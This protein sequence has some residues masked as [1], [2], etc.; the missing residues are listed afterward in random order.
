MNIRVIFFYIIYFLAHVH[1]LQDTHSMN[2]LNK[3]TILYEQSEGKRKT[4][5]MIIC[6]PWLYWEEPIV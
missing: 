3:I 4:L 1:R 2:S 6:C 5:R